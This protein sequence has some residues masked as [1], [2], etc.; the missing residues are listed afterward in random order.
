MSAWPYEENY[1]DEEYFGLMVKIFF[2][3]LVDMIMKKYMVKLNNQGNDTQN[4]Y[5]H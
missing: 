4:N 1:K 2:T 3:S 5:I